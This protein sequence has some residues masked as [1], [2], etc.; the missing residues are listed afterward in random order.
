MGPGRR[1]LRTGLDARPDGRRPLLVRVRRPAAAVRRSPGL[2]EGVCPPGGPVWQGQ[3]AAVVPRGPRLYPGPRRRRGHVA[4]EPPGREGTAGLPRILVTDRARRLGV[5]G[6]PVPGGGAALRAESAGQPQA[7]RGGLE[8]AVAGPGPPAPRQGRGGAALAGQGPGMARSV[9]RR[10]AGRRGSGRGAAPAQ[11]AGGARPAPRGGSTA[12]ADR[13]P[14]WY[15]KPGARR[16]TEMNSV[17]LG[18]AIE[19]CRSAR[20]QRPY[21]GVAL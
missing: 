4:A 9:W 11:L 6:R 21:L 5:P 19:Y 2:R 14:K 15:G 16:A 13:S 8:L 20:G 17:R 1:W 7:G 18:E 10:D 3:V 12:S